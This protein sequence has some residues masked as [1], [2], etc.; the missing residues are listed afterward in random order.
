MIIIFCPANF[1]FISQKDNF[2]DDMWYI[3]TIIVGFVDCNEIMEFPIMSDLGDVNIG[4]EIFQ[5]KRSRGNVQYKNLNRRL[6]NDI[7]LQKSF[8]PFTC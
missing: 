4:N 1:S 8:N 3:M 2:H 5:R 6:N 7:L